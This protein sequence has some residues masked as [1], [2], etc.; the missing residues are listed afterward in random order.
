MGP[1][2]KELVAEYGKEAPAALGRARGRSR[3]MLEVMSRHDCEAA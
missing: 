3:M 2:F 1:A